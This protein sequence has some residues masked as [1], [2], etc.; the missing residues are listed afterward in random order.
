MKKRRQAS[1]RT[2]AEAQ[3]RSAIEEIARAG[4]SHLNS[5]S[6]VAELLHVWLASRK[7]DKTLVPRTIGE[8]AR[9]IDSVI[10][11]AM[12]T[13]YLYEVTPAVVDLHL[14]RV[15]ERTPGWSG[16]MRTVLRQAFEMAERYNAVPSSPVRALRPLVTRRAKAEALDA[17]QVAQLRRIIAEWEASDGRRANGVG[18]IV[19]FMLGTG[20]RISE[21]LALQWKDLYLDSDPAT[22]VIRG[23]MSQNPV[24]GLRRQEGRKGHAVRGDLGLELTLPTWLRDLLCAHRGDHVDRTGS[25]PDPDSP[26]FPGRGGAFRSP[27][28]TRTTLRKILAGTPFEGVFRP[29][30]LRK[31][32]ATAVKAELGIDAAS[33]QLGHS[34][35]AVTQKHYI[36]EPAK[37]PDVR[38]ALEAF[39]PT[40]STGSDET[41]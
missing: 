19:E 34:G 14:Q 17:Q 4:G 13:L 23:A 5:Q 38:S 35:V 29:H 3:L 25:T 12:G 8:Y 18:L 1:T 16:Q 6:T 11:P 28:N 36:A 15:H 40:T 37:A 20:V 21:A 39:A 27:H 41:S 30:M 31:T 7:A 10:I 22:V 26:V 2:A 24:E 9:V 33:K 32:V